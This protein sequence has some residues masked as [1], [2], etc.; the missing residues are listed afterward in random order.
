M[1]IKKEDLRI[2]ILETAKQ[3]F[4]KKGY[5]NSSMRVIAKK[6]NTTLGNVYTYFPSKE[7]ILEEILN[8]IMEDLKCL[9]NE[10]LKYR[11]EI[12]SMDEIEAIMLEIEKSFD[13][14]E[15]RYLLHKELIILLDLKTTKFVAIREEFIG[16]CK[17]HMAWHLK[18]PEENN[19]FAATIVTMFIDCLRHVLLED[20][21]PK[22]VKEEFVKV[23]Q[24]LCA[25]I[26]VVHESNE[27]C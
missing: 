18:F 16:K 4:I 14:S 10:H 20:K 21:D 3:E 15:M 24:M 5:E 11:G 7:G 13:S 6:A 17:R 8:P 19:L 12:A 25:G 27:E 1:Q 23:F 2:M 9:E 26:G 22:L